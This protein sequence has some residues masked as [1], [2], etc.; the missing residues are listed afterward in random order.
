MWRTQVGRIS[1]QDLPAM[2]RAPQS[3]SIH[4]AK[5]PSLQRVIDERERFE[6]PGWRVIAPDLRGYGES[7]VIPG[8]TTLDVFA[9]D[10][11]TLLDQLNVREVVIGG[12]SM[13]G[14]IVIDF[15]RLYPHPLPGISLPAPSPKAST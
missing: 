7:S 6:R 14:R 4:G 15:S 1:R 2:L 9:Q 8:K 10:I 13:C 5:T 12:L 11:A 3:I